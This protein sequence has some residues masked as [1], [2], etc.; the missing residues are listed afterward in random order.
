ML[1]ILLTLSQD[2][3]LKIERLYNQ[4]GKLMF[5]VANKILKDK[6]SAEDA[7]Q[8]AFIRIANNLHKINEQNGHETKN[9]MVIIIRNVSINIYNEQNKI[10][11]IEIDDLDLVDDEKSIENIIMSNE[12][13]NHLIQLIQNLKPI[14]QDVI[15]LRYQNYTHKEISEIL[16]IKEQT[17]RKRLE[18]GK[19]KLRKLLEFQNGGDAK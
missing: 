17:V 14:Y 12:N 16:K 4:Y 1:Q 19:K 8:Q 11:T 18:R 5:H 9:F 2:D 15:L 6:Y 7:V 13:L 10:A 3:G